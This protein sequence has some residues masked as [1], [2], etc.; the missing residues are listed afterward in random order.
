MVDNDSSQKSIQEL[1]APEFAVVLKKY[2]DAG[3]GQDV[4]MGSKPWNPVELAKKIKMSSSSIQ[5]YLKEGLIPLESSFHNL[6]CFGL[7][8]NRF[9]MIDGIWQTPRAYRELFEA[10]YPG[11]DLPE[12]KPG[13]EPFAPAPV[14]HSGSTPIQPRIE[15][16]TPASR[17]PHRNA[18]PFKTFPKL[19]VSLEQRARQ[20]E[21][22]IHQLLAHSGKDTPLRRALDL[23]LSRWGDHDD[24]QEDIREFSIA[25]APVDA[26]KL[27]TALASAIESCHTDRWQQ[28]GTS[29]ELS[30]LRRWVERIAKLVFTLGWTEVAWV[31]LAKADFETQ[32]HDICDGD[33]LYAGHN[34]ALGRDF[35]LPH[36][37]LIDKWRVKI[38]PA[39]D[40][41][42]GRD[43]EESIYDQAALHFGAS[44]RPIFDRSG[45]A[46][47]YRNRL[48]EWHED[49]AD[50]VKVE[51]DIQRR[52]VSLTA[53]LNDAATKQVI[54]ELQKYA[55]AIHSDLH[56]WNGRPGKNLRCGERLFLRALYALQLRIQQI[57]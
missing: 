19:T 45:S 26:Y 15:Q 10:A 5:K 49:V 27:I 32:I 35:E 8:I 20:V 29:V 39:I 9:E 30:A 25:T 24:D 33:L 38:D 51:S 23:L 16:P 43:L 42:I 41:G 14:I 50:C 21:K 34:A 4:G 44:S 12:H 48:A 56:A 22:A 7:K 28:Q 52:T 47:D 1:K 57:P 36:S 46:E 18:D 2:M 3:T 37:K 55:K 53:K 31:N 40:P 11:R 17:A 54:S 6:V 13:S